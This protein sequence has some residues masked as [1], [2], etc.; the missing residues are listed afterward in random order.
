MILKF[1]SVRIDGIPQGIVLEDQERMTKIQELVDKLRA[2]YH[3]E[4]RH[5]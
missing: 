1:I 4:I 2:G 5:V 3:T